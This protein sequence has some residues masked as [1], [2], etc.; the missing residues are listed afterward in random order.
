MNYVK[1]SFAGL[2][3]REITMNPL[4][5]I[6]VGGCANIPTICH[7]A[8]IVAGEGQARWATIVKTALAPPSLTGWCGFRGIFGSP[9]RTP[10]CFEPHLLQLQQ[11]KVL[12]APSD[13]SIR[14]SD[15]RGFVRYF[16]V[17]KSDTTNRAIGDCRQTDL[18]VE[19]PPGVIFP[20]IDEIFQTMQF[21]RHF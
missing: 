1:L 20:S 16:E 13:L 19:R 14:P 12:S 11:W 21:G 18:L 9:L 10:Q 17:K 6:L 2:Q 8:D 15:G 4:D 5:E 7:W 3:G